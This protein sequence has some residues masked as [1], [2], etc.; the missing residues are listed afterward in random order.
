[1][2]SLEMRRLAIKK[3]R[4]EGRGFLGE[5]FFGCGV[6]DGVGGVVGVMFCVVI[7]VWI[8]GG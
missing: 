8:G 7:F 3:N 2:K 6:M 5:V 4:A 1:M